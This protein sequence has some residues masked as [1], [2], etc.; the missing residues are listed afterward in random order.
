MLCCNLVLFL[1]AC[2]AKV[3]GTSFAQTECSVNSKAERPNVKINSNNTC[4]LNRPRALK[5]NIVFCV[6]TQSKMDTETAVSRVHRA[7][8]RLQRVSWSTCKK[9]TELNELKQRAWVA[10]FGGLI[11]LFCLLKRW[12][13]LT[14]N[15]ETGLLN[16]RF[17]VSADSST[18][19]KNFCLL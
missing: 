8:P 11:L 1:F 6:K 9:H 16:A 13:F 18:A 17:A 14:L 2:T 5:T 19:A 7:K 12:V 4:F 3:T 10:V 15:P